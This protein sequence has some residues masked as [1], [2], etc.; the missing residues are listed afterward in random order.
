MCVL[1]SHS[2]RDVVIKCPR[3][4]LDYGIVAGLLLLTV[5]PYISVGRFDFVA[6]DDPQYVTQ[7]ELVRHGLEPLAMWGA[8]TEFHA[9][10]WHPLVW[11]SLM[12]DVQL[13][14]LSPG[15]F[16][17]VNVGWHLA[18]VVTLYFAMRSL[19]GDRWRSAVIAAIF[20]VHPLH[21]ES[22]A[23]ITERKDVLS[24]FF[25]MLGLWA[26]AHWARTRRSHWWWLVTFCLIGGL[27][28]K[29][30]VVTLPCVFLLLDG[31]PLGR[32][33]NAQVGATLVRR[34][35]A[36]VAE[37]LFWFGLCFGAVVIV[38]QAQTQA[39]EYADDWPLSLRLSN[40]ALSVMRY[41]GKVFWP[42]HLGVQ[43]PYN[44][45]ES[46]VSVYASAAAIGAISM[47]AIL[48]ARKWPFLL[49][50]WCWF[51]GTLAPVSGFVQAGIQSIADRYMYLP[52]VGISVAIVWLVPLPRS[53]V[54][55][56]AF[57]GV[58]VIGMGALMFRAEQQVQVWRN[59]NTLFRHALAIDP[60]NDSAHYILAAG[61]LQEGRLA[62]GIA[63]LEV[64]VEWERRRWEARRFFG[65]QPDPV[66]LTTVNRGC[67]DIYLQIGQAQVTLGNSSEAI[68]ALQEALRLDPD[69]WDASLLLG[70][71]LAQAG[72]IDAARARFE[73]IL[74]RRPG[75]PEALRE[76]AQLNSPRSSLR[77]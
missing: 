22:V 72:E 71:V 8:L 53:R 56:W 75:H 7:S 58:V 30:I 64:A 11:W 52:L 74:R 46:M 38:L 49:T 28:S 27:M 77:D 13:F 50:G 68:A 4:W 16:H 73:E 18:N 70:R 41:L 12:L 6:L 1:E 14:G 29:Q 43:Y 44:P 55:L 54:A 42:T 45:P 36:L 33:H 9:D 67:A 48:L 69:L 3:V 59:T 40:A 62:E 23:W 17:L 35:K 51:L 76:L 61:D 2:A 21:V 24:G 31:W 66:K 57:I 15:P 20:G 60:T 25:W 65:G 10:N 19:T 37:K 32:L 63:H 39:R 34:V 26:Y 5:I 47:M